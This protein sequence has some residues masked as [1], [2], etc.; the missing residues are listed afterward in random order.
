MATVTGDRVITVRLT[1]GLG[2][3]MFQYAVARRLA[4]KHGT[5]VRLDTS[6]YGSWLTGPA[7]ANRRFEL[8]CLR[9]EDPLIP[10]GARLATIQALRAAANQLRLRHMPIPRRYYFE[11]PHHYHFDARVLDLPDGSD[12]SGFL[13]SEK[14]FADVADHI[15]REFT[16]RDP[17]LA[18]NVA[19]R[20]AQLRRSGRKLVSL[21][22]RR[23]DY[24][25]MRGGTNLLL[26]DYFTTAMA[27]F[28][29]CDFL[30]ESDDLDWCRANVKGDNILYSPFETGFE[31]LIAMTHCDSNIIANSSMSWWGAWLN[32]RPDKTVVAPAGW[33][34][35]WSHL[36]LRDR[37]IHAEGWV[38]I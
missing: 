37:D 4:L 8:L 36:P 21:H 30:V 13:Q 23:G 15:R 6:A 16:P 11:P 29:G 7:D 10:D 24:L 3:Q 34:N 38:R 33:F 22:V 9:V 20:V 1:G 35:A 17:L 2:N 26:P 18:Q 12:L 19:R 28:E 5:R 25:K 32:P 31:A 14:Y 27:R